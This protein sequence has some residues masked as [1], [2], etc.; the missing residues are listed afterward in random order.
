MKFLIAS[1][2][3]GSSE[4][5]KLL[6]QAFEKEKADKLILLGDIYNHGPRNPLPNGYNPLEVAQLLNSISKNLIVIRGNCDSCV[7][8]IISDFQFIQDSIIVINNKIIYLQH[9]DR[10][11]INSLPKIEFDIFIYGHYHT[12]FIKMQG[13]RFIANCGSVALPKNNTAKSYLL[14]TENSLELKDLDSQM[15]DSYIFTK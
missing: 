5:T 6:L 12:G 3:H 2:L 7:D 11:N 9:G 14:L 10:Y 1:D 8:E 15:I 13:N 4:S